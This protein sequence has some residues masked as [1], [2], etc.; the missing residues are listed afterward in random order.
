MVKDMQ[1]YLKMWKIILKERELFTL[2]LTL[3]KLG[4]VAGETGGISSMK[5]SGHNITKQVYY[6]LVAVY[7]Q[8]KLFRKSCDLG[9]S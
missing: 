3:Y 9:S 2:L 8:L 7:H 4:A 5:L 1:K 6:F